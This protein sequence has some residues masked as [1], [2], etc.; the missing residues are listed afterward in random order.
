MGDTERLEEGIGAEGE[1]EEV[2]GSENANGEISVSSEEGGAVVADKGRGEARP[3][4]LPPLA[5]IRG[6]AELGVVGDL[7]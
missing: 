5:I 6:T 7:G 1:E 2:E 4:A 3:L